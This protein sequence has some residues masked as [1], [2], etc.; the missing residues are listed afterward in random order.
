M[1]PITL[2]IGMVPLSGEEGDIH[3]VLAAADDACYIA[4]EEGGNRIR[5]LPKSD[6]K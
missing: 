1:F 3:A 4:K 6:E 2:S 5:R